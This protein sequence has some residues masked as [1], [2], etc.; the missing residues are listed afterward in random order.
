M[1]SLEQ[2]SSS[3]DSGDMGMILIGMPGIREAHRSLAR[4][5]SRIGFVHKFRPLGTDEVQELLERCW[6]SPGVTCLTVVLPRSRSA[7]LE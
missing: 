2:V 4:L 6:T 1:N 7:W 5:Y 3:F